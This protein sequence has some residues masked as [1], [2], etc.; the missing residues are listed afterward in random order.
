VKFN[1]GKN[2]LRVVAKKYG[3]IH[4]TQRHSIHRRSDCQWRYSHIPLSR[5]IQA[6][7]C[8][9]CKRS[10]LASVHPRATGVIAFRRY[11]T[12]LMRSSNARAQGRNH[13]ER[14]YRTHGA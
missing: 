7:R 1:S 2:H 9:A 14:R 11:V 10:L 8:I 12:I 3:L 6:S 5:L 4:C 13:H